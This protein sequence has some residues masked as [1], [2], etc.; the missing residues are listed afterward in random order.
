MT[1]VNVTKT[2]NVPAASVW[3]KL[4]S[5]RGIEKF[6]PIARSVAEGEGVGTKRTCYMPDNAEIKE[7]LTKL[8]NEN[9]QLEYIIL[10]GP[11]PI[12]DYVSTVKVKAIDEN[13]CEVS[14]GSTFVVGE[15]PESDIIGL[16]DNFYNV[17][18]DS[19]E[20]LI[21]AEKLQEA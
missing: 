19:L 6:S 10:S 18:I 15:A 9:M 5:F 8:D 17:I 14:W 2:I 1:N 11:F 7:E 21:K 4:E 16:F 13:T 3:A 12:T 20:A